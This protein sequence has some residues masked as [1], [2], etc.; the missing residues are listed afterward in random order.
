MVSEF[1]EGF[2]GLMWEPSNLQANNCWDETEHNSLKSAWLV[3]F[4]KN[5]IPWWDPLTRAIFW[6]VKGLRI[7]VAMNVIVS[8]P[9]VSKW[10]W[11]QCDSSA[12][13]DAYG[14]HIYLCRIT[15]YYK[16]SATIIRN[17]SSIGKWRAIR[18]QNNQGHLRRPSRFQKVY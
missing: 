1:G 9:Y 5:Y 3:I 7:F 6:K 4:Y 14:K 12:N 15:Y 2:N 17:S 16:T 11:R 18:N 10:R 8:L 13:L